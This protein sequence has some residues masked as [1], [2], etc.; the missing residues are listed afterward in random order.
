MTPP[1]CAASSPRT[2]ATP[3]GH[4]HTRSSS[5]VRTGHFTVEDSLDYIAAH[6][7][8]FYGKLSTVMMKM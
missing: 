7:I 3:L 1:A 4:P 5:G 2:G 6:M 8:E